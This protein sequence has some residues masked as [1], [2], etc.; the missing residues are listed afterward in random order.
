MAG[1]PLDIDDVLESLRSARR[2]HALAVLA[3]LST[4]VTL[5]DLADEVAIRE[6]AAPI[7]EI[8][9]EDVQRVYIGLYHSHVPKLVELDLLEYHQAGDLVTP[10]ETVGRVVAIMHDVDEHGSESDADRGTN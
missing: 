7:D 6:H 5:A 1:G 4:T 2:R 8:A 9:A 10:S 3:E